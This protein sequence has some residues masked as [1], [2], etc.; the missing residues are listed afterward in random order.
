M[1]KAKKSKKKKAHIKGKTNN[2]AFESFGQHII[3]NDISA[4]AKDLSHLLDIDENL[5]ESCATHFSKQ[6]LEDPEFFNKA[7]E[8]RYRLL[9]GKNDDALI[10][11]QECFGLQ[12][13]QSTEAL[14]AITKFIDKN[15]I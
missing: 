5:G 11:L 12:G 13:I 2:Q 15:R 9:L 7:I 6:Y 14:E 8:M 1:K 3:N 10:L 4:A